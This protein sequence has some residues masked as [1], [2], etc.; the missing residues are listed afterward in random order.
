[1][2][3]VRFTESPC[4]AWKGRGSSSGAQGQGLVLHWQMWNLHTSP[5]KQVP[6]LIS[7]P[8]PSLAEPQS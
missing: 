2:R 1:V 8:Q 7:L 4:E 6:Q 5:V 3:R